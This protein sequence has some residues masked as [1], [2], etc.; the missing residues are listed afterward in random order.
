MIVLEQIHKSQ[1]SYVMNLPISIPLTLPHLSQS[2]CMF[3]MHFNAGFYQIETTQAD[4][5]YPGRLEQK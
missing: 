3:I 2:V 1:I 4:K 5:C